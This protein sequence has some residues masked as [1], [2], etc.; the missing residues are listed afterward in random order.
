MDAILPILVIAESFAA[1]IIYLFAAKFGS[2]IYWL[3][4]GT[5]NLAALYLIKRFG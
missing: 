1:G 5:I 3:A 2:A 4:A